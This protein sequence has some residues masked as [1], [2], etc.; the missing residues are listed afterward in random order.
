MNSP[1]SL[2]NNPSEPLLPSENPDLEQVSNQQALP[3]ENN[4]DPEAPEYRDERTTIMNR[5]S[6]IESRLDHGWYKCFEY[7]LYVS[8]VVT[9]II[10]TRQGLIYLDDLWRYGVY[11]WT[12]VPLVALFV[13]CV[14]NFATCWT[15]LQAIYMLSLEKAERAF[16]M[17][18]GFLVFYAVVLIFVFFFEVP[19]FGIIFHIYNVNGEMLLFLAL[20]FTLIG[21]TFEGARKVRNKLEKRYNLR[22]GLNSSIENNPNSA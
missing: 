3:E 10:I 6:S 7:W 21:I 12:V 4:N 19:S 11:S 13:A 14:W 16:R 20:N 17:I 5:I 8:M 15:E 2:I 22:L 1:I 9:A 18:K